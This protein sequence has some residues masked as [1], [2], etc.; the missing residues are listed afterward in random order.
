MTLDKSALNKSAL[1]GP[2]IGLVG[3]LGTLVCCVLPAIFVTLGAGASLAGLLSVF[4]QLIFL[5]EHKGWVFGL[6]AAAIALAGIMRYR[7]RNAPCPAD[8]EQAAACDRLRKIS[9][10]MLAGAAVIWMTGF[11]FAFIAPRIFF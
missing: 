4:P 1:A 10:Y 9:V 6:S 3:S 7:Q 8:P 2:I 11:F 5:S